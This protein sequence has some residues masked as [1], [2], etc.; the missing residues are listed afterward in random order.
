MILFFFFLASFGSYRTPA[1]PP[2]IIGRWDI[3]I[4]R[5]DGERRMA[6][7]AHSGVDTLVGQFVGMSGS[8]RPISL[9]EFKACEMLFTIP[10]QWERVGP[11]V[12]EGRLDGDRLTGSMRLGNEAPMAWTGVRAPTLRRPTPPQWGAPVSLFNGHDLTGWHAIGTNEWEAADGVLRNKKS[13]GNLVT[14]RTFTDFKLHTEF[15]YPAG[16]NSGVY[17]RGRY[18]VQ[19]VD[20]PAAEPA[21]DSLGAVYGFL[22]P[23]KTPRAN[24]ASGRP[25]DITRSPAGW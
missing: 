4:Q 17:L 19:I 13:G 2:P 11:I 22:T 9:V 25:S 16:S 5:P 1:R 20:S 6:R 10:P 7:G 8:A 12:V 24:R 15:R 18:E 14:D 3:A 23:G 21:N